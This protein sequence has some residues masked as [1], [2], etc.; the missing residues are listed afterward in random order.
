MNFGFLGKGNAATGA[1][2]AEQ[3]EESSI[4]YDV[5]LVDL[6]RRSVQDSTGIVDVEDENVAPQKV[7]VT[8]ACD[9]A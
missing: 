6:A 9:R 7:E 4:P 2:L 1:P 3:I 5:D 8:L